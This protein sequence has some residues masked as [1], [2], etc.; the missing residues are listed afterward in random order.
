MRYT[1]AAG[2]WIDPAR[3]PT[4]FLARLPKRALISAS[5]SRLLH[6][7]LIA[8]CWISSRWRSVGHAEQPDDVAEAKGMFPGAASATTAGTQRGNNPF[9][10][11]RRRGLSE[12]FIAVTRFLCRLLDLP[13]AI[14]VR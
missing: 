12:E 2:V 9:F 14:F 6:L 5:R 4:L 8:R 1:A 13:I 10:H 11:P 7:P 3:L